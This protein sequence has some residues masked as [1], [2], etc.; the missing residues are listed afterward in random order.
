[1]FYGEEN[2]FVGELQVH[3]VRAL[4]IISPSDLH[5]YLGILW[6]THSVQIIMVKDWKIKYFRLT[7]AENTI[8]CIPIR[9]YTGVLWFS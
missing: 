8:N 6:M 4:I 7:L 5:I 1:M 9:M 3:M 2:Q